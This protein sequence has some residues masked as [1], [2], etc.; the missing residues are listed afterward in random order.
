MYLARAL[1]GLKR[2]V[3]SHPPGQGVPKILWSCSRVCYWTFNI[4]NFLFLYLVKTVPDSS[5]CTV[6]ISF[7]SGNSWWG[8]VCVEAQ[9]SHQIQIQ[10]LI[11]L[12]HHHS[13]KIAKKSPGKR[14]RKRVLGRWL[15]K[16]NLWL[17]LRKRKEFKVS[18]EVEGEV[19]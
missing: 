9:G 8:E 6:K 19:N 16:R 5:S 3:L 4:W 2:L 15:R 17:R 1:H 18:V 14:N 12:V 10:F 11:I 13:E 7:L